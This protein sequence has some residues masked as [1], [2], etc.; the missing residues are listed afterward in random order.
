MRVA[1]LGATGL[2][3]RTMLELLEACDWVDTPPLALASAHSAGQ[4]LPWRGS[5]ILCRAVAPG[6]FAGIDLALF[7]AGGGPSRE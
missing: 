6:A 2:V 3:G 4:A 5:E 1:V 7:S